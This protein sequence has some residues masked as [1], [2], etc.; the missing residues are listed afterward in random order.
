MATR[1]LVL[2]P[3]TRKAFRWTAEGMHEVA[4]LRIEEPEIRVP[5]SALFD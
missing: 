3:A 5:V 4:E 1:T 2:D